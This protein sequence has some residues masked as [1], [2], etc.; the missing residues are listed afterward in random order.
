MMDLAFS[1]QNKPPV[2]L[3]DSI[4]RAKTFYGGHKALPLYEHCWLVLGKACSVG[5]VETKS[6]SE[7]ERDLSRG[8]VNSDLA[9]IILYHVVEYER[10]RSSGIVLPYPLSE[11]KIH[12][13]IEIFSAI[14]QLD[15][16]CANLD[17]YAPLLN[18]GHAPLALLARIADYA[19]THR[20]EDRL[21]GLVS[22]EG[23]PIY[24]MYETREEAREAMNAEAHA[25][26]VLYAPAAELFGYP[27]L[28]GDILYHAYGVK[29]RAVYDHVISSIDTDFLDS[30]LVFTRSL[31]DN[32]AQVMEAHLSNLGFEA[33]VIPRPEKHKGKIMRKV[34]RMLA[35]DYKNSKEQAEGMSADEYVAI[36]I[37]KF[38]L[39]TLNDLVALRVIVDKFQGREI[40]SMEDKMVVMRF[41][42]DAIRETIK[43]LLGNLLNGFNPVST[44]NDKSNGYKAFHED[45]EPVGDHRATR[46]EIQVKTR[47]WHSVAEQGGAAHY[48]YLGGHPEFMNLIAEAY[49]HMIHQM[50]GNG[51]K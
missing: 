45:I 26:E 3:E 5:M 51:K 33:E 48:Y 28:A 24:R 15:R 17:E 41:A 14:T 10:M 19:V 37:R 21:E 38:D 29:H 25:G 9:E 40:D 7:A 44:F 12:R 16:R 1:R 20:M 4:A 43:P 49:K 18:N 30:R 34:L 13:E 36:K 32:L 50:N 6:I 47:E 11:D 46:F 22:L 39:G 2:K 27:T 42:V 8:W 23:S 31:V 35:S